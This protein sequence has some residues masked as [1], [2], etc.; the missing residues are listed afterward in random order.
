MYEALGTC[1]VQGYCS[2][3]WQPS[4]TYSASQNVSNVNGIYDCIGGGVSAS[5]GTGPG[6]AGTGIV[7]G[8]ALWSFLATPAEM[9]LLTT[10]LASG[11]A[12]PVQSFSI[13]AA[14]A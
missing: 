14:N 11:L 5:V 8:S 13:T 10:N 12:L 6:G 4:T 3:I 9:I 2:E 1:H 7:D